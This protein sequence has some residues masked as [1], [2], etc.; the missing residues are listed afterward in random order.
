MVHIEVSPGAALRCAAPWP[1]ARPLWACALRGPR[2]LG[3]AAAVPA[4]RLENGGIGAG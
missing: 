1:P 4:R 2:G 3:R